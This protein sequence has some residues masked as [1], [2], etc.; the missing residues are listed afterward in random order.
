MDGVN[1]DGVL[2]PWGCRTLLP[3]GKRADT[4]TLVSC[5]VVWTE[6]RG[7]RDPQ[8]VEQAGPSPSH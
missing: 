8:G 5:Q 4:H 1:E 2:G 6:T 7:L 3:S